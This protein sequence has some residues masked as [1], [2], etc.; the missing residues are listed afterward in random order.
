MWSGLPTTGNKAIDGQEH[1][2]PE[3]IGGKLKLPVGD[4]SKYWNHE[5]SRLGL[6]RVLKKDNPNIKL[7]YQR[8]PFMPGKRPGDKRKKDRRNQEKKEIY[9]TDYS[10]CI[11]RDDQGNTYMENENFEYFNYDFSRAIHKCVANVICYEKG[12]IYVRDYFIELL[13]FVKNEGIDNPWAWSYAASFANPFSPLCIRPIT[14]KL[15]FSFNHDL[16]KE[17]IWVCFAHTSGIWLAA[18][19]PHAMSKEKIESFS[20]SIRD[21][22]RITDIENAGTDIKQ[23]FGMAWDKD[24][25]LIG[26]L[27]FLWV[28]KQIEG[29]PNPEDSFYLL[30]KCKVCGQINPTG[31]MI[32]KTMILDGNQNNVSSTHKNSWNYYS[33]DDL[34]RIGFNTDKWDPNHLERYINTQGIRI[35]L[36]NDIKKLNITNCW[37]KCINC[38][39]LIKYDANDCF[40]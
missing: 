21:H 15:V 4:V 3:S 6:D 14:I 26:E 34:K 40:L 1:V 2:F 5:L 10:A 11:R 25:E 30:T 27:K 22:P 23:I 35:P 39:N 16:K 12:S 29:Q 18:S 28:K 36:E 8:D 32:E 20:N 33:T 37:C 31:I 24:R 38:G 19:Q 17:C 13:N 7:A 9:S